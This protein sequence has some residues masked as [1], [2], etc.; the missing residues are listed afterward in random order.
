M[1]GDSVLRQNTLIAANVFLSDVMHHQGP[2]AISGH[3]LVLFPFFHLSSI[4][5]P[6]HL[7][8]NAVNIETITL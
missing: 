1:N 4:P 5:H 3:I 6:D 7:K 2:L 8:A